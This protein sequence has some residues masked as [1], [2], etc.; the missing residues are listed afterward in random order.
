MA[1]LTI[2]DVDSIMVEYEDAEEV[3]DLRNA[4]RMINGVNEEIERLEQRRLDLIDLIEQREAA[5]LDVAN[6]EGWEV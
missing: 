4:Y 3:F 6:R 5:L 1:N 2:E